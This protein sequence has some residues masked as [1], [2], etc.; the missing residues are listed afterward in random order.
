MGEP[1]TLYNANGEAVTVYTRSQAETMLGGGE[2]YATAADA[3]AGRVRE[4]P[5]TTTAAK[6]DA[7]EAAADGAATLT[8]NEPAQPAAAPAPA[9]TTAA[10]RTTRGKG[11]L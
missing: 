1:V 4:E 8:P 11:G 7:L 10:T 9:K 2:W 3:G 6:L 5:T